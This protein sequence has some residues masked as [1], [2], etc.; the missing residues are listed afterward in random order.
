MKIA[1]AKFSLENHDILKEIFFM[2]IRCIFKRDRSFKF[3][4]M[5]HYKVHSVFVEREMHFLFAL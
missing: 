4:K 3:T 2:S 5:K 1:Q